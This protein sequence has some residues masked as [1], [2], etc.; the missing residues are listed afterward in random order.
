MIYI[1]EFLFTFFMTFFYS[2][3]NYYTT[4]QATF[5]I[6]VT[7]IAYSLDKNCYINLGVASSFLFTG[8]RPVL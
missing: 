7:F 8:Y 3:E 6:L 1:Y 4:V 5:V 2:I